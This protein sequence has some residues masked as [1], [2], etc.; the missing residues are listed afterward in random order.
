MVCIV[1]SAARELAKQVETL[2]RASQ[3]FYLTDETIRNLKEN[4]MKYLNDEINMDD[5]FDYLGETYFNPLQ[6]EV[7]NTWWDNTQGE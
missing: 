1:L 5:E 3:V 2:E 6:A 7:Y 4:D